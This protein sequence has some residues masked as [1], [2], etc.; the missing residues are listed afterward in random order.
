LTV[1]RQRRVQKIFQ[2][3][4]DTPA[5][6]RS[7]FLDD[8]CADDP[9]LKPD[10]EQ[11]IR[12]F[13]AAGSFLESSPASS[14]AGRVFGSYQIKTLLG[15]GGMGQV[16]LASDS[17]LK[18]DVAIKVLP[19]EFCS[20]PER[21]SRFQREAEVLASL[22]HPHIAAIYDLADF[23]ELRF[24]VLEL[25]EGDTL[26]D[27]LKKRGALPMVEALHIS[28]QI[29][30]A[31]E[32]A[33]EKG[34]VHR[35]LKPANVKVTADGNVKVLDFGLAKTVEKQTPNLSHSDSLTSAA[36]GMILGT[37]AYMSPEQAK[38][39]SVDRR[40]DIF[41]FGCLLYAMLTGQPTFDGNDTTEILGRVVTA[42]P[43]WSRLPAKTPA[44]IRQ[45]LRRMLRKES[46]ERLGDIRDARLEIEDAL[47]EPAADMAK[48]VPPR[49]RGLIW[50]IGVLAIGLATLV[51]AYFYFRRSP[52]AAPAVRFEIAVPRMLDAYQFSVSPDGQRFAYVAGNSEGKNALWVR[53]LG[54]LTPQQLPATDIAGGQPLFWSPDS[55]YIGFVSGGKLKKI[56]VLGGT[57]ETICDVLFAS[58]RGGTWNREGAILFGGY[59]EDQL[60]IARVSG[61][62]RVVVP[63]T[64]PDAPGE[65]HSAPFFL[66]DGRH[67][68]Y[69]AVPS[70][71][72]YVGSLDSKSTTPLTLA[73]DTG[74]IYAG[75][76]LLFVRSGTL[77][78]QAF[79]PDLIA[80]KGHPIPVA[81]GVQWAG[82]RRAFSASTNGVLAY[83]SSGRDNESRELLW[84]DRNG[85]STSQAYKASSDIESIESVNLSRNG[86]RIAIA[87]PSLSGA[88]SYISV[89]DVRRAV[90]MRLT[91]G[92]AST[93]Q[94]IDQDTTPIW[95]PD[96]SKVVFARQENAMAKLYQKPSTGI[97][98]E[99][100]LFM[101]D[102]NE[103]AAHWISAQDWSV[104]ARYIVLTRSRGAPPVSHLWALPSF[105][106]RKPF[107]LVPSPSNQVHAQL[108]P[109]GRWLAYDT[110]ESGMYQIVVQSF[111]DSGGGKWPL[112]A[113]GGVEP[114]WRHDGRELYYLALDGK[115]MAVPL[116]GGGKFEASQPKPLFQTTITVSPTQ[117]AKRDAN[118][119]YD[120]TGD[121]QRFL[122]LSY[123]PTGNSAPTAITTVLNWTA[124]L[125]EK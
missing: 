2:D 96:E 46:R 55:Q 65:S 125:H 113:E 16:Y 43:D 95:A 108:S 42:E 72:V 92:P 27:I 114:R 83:L 61:S 119:H 57:P 17:K 21:L 40:S 8:A 76:Y 75:G 105:G 91:F 3:A 86:Q 49:S 56:D 68:L 103:R 63:A 13:E 123:R 59:L 89:I 35:D 118:Y 7:R 115:L 104:D 14:L 4:L 67:F 41:S 87:T 39:L 93:S 71:T 117:D 120:V 22:N 77:M 12:S 73:A 48:V 98:T 31:L 54:S 81:E 78:A 1:D 20:D 44:S 33:H 97:G 29:C 10:V 94:T 100:L 50:T 70:R 30:E 6:E 58:F 23:G 107:P 45:L 110:N 25:V 26:A 28:K 37:A 106:D 74:A 90:P 80:L 15:S 5:S 79:D 34:I 36:G 53:A 69:F 19:S 85:N 18:R 112:T 60:V 47:T 52:G 64:L 111:P 51:A 88:E 66:P 109:D 32:V 102:S 124:D 121:G 9:S 82:S 24:L 101:E 38:G 99:E 122:L 11:L 116:T 84:F 62:S